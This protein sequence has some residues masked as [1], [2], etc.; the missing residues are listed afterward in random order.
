MVTNW[1]TRQSNKCLSRVLVHC[2]LPQ[3]Y[4]AALA[5]GFSQGNGGTT[6]TLLMMG[7]EVRHPRYT[8]CPCYKLLLNVEMHYFT[9]YYLPICTSFLLLSY[10]N[11]GR[12]PVNAFIVIYVLCC[13]VQWSYRS[14]SGQF[15]ANEVC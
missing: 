2:V 11:S 1:L 13:H 14:K 3:F 9:S 7:I 4:I 10:C 15:G 8:L 6:K 12:K 5:A